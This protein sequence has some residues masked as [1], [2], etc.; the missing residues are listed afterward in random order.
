M[1]A[2]FLVEK[3][4]SL[5]PG[6]NFTSGRGPRISSS[7]G[8]MY[9]GKVGTSSEAEQYRAEI[10]S[11]EL[12]STAAPGLCPNVISASH[13]GRPYLI[14]NYLNLSSLSS[15]AGASNILAR[16]LATELHAA[17]SEN[18]KYGFECPTFCGA[19]KIDNGWYDTWADAYSAMIGG[20]LDKLERKGSYK[21][22]CGK[23]RE[24]QQRAIPH[25]LGDRLKGVEPVLCHGDLWSGNVGADADGNP[26]IFDPSSYYGH[27]ESDLAIGRIFGGFSPAFYHEYHS[28]RPKSEPVEEYDQRLKLYQFFHYLNHTVLF[29]G[30]YSSQAMNLAN[31]LLKPIPS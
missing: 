30:G 13:E 25:Y 5:F 14:S 29:G 27:N 6:D 8:R 11:L 10:R 31:Q 2:S 4:G 21:E 28:L 17:K 19:T 15:S 16:R 1:S 18:E 26:A 9:Y 12:M 3:L 23:G 22:L 20:L 24:V 7:S